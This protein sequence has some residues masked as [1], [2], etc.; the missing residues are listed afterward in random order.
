MRSVCTWFMQRPGRSS[1]QA[2]EAGFRSVI[3]RRSRAPICR[4]R[5]NS[6][7][8]ANKPMTGVSQWRRNSAHWQPVSVPTRARADRAGYNGS[9]KDGEFAAYTGVD[10]PGSILRTVHGIYWGTRQS[11]LTSCGVQRGMR[12]SPVLHGARHA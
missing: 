9:K 2:F 11:V 3:V 8:G 7:K 12:H 4:E 10:G 5:V 6:K 1:A